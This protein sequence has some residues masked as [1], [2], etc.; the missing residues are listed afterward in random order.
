MGI[1]SGD[2][3]AALGIGPGTQPGL[4]KPQF[5]FSARS[6]GTQ[7]SVFAETDC[8]DC[9]SPLSPPG[10]L[11]PLAQ[12]RRDAPLESV[13]IRPPSQN[14]PHWD[15]SCHVPGAN[16]MP[17]LQTAPKSLP[18]LC[19][20]LPPPYLSSIV[21]SLPPSCPFSIHPRMNNCAPRPSPATVHRSELGL[22][23][24][25]GWQTPFLLPMGSS[26]TGLRSAHLPPTQ[27]LCP[28]PI[29]PYEA[30]SEPALLR[31][32][33]SDPPTP[34]KSRCPMTCL[35]STLLPPRNPYHSL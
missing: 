31:D 32:S 26:H 34:I 11:Q 2:E 22:A 14:S 24:P 35:P 19:L 10:A 16:P 33:I 23:D 8:G 29:T 3:G 9:L 12:P 28:H 5:H 21:P 30:P 25:A 15:P 7:R 6:P 18:R 1:K 27:A 13:L 20:P 4:N 17:S